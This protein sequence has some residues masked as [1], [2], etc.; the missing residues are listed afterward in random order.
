M[1]EWIELHTHLLALHIKV[2]GIHTMTGLKF[3]WFSVR[4]LHHAV[5]K[6]SDASEFSHPEN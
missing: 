2:C 5:V 6:Y 1:G 4:F 3:R